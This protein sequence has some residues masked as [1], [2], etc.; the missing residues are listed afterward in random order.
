MSPGNTKQFSQIAIVGVGQVGGAAAY[1]LILGSV[2]SELLLVDVKVDLRDGQVRDL[3]DVAYSVNSGTRVRAATHHEAGQ[4]DIV[5]ITAG[6]RWSIGE[7]NIQHMHRNVSIMRSV[8][9]A[10][11]PFRADAIVLVVSNPVDLLTSIAQEISGLP[12][13]QVLGSGTFLDSVRLRGLL[14]DKTGMAASSIQV[15]VVGVHGDS[16]VVAWSAAT[17][18][19]MPINRSLLPDTLQHA[20]LADECKHRSESIIRA[21]G[22][23]PFGISSVVSSICSSILLD[24]GDVEPIS[25]FQPEFSCCFSLPVILGRKGIMRVI[26]V[27]LDSHE[28][29]DIT[30]SAKRLRDVVERIQ[31]DH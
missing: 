2:A 13:S 10:M 29:A 19:G 3:S 18:N 28:Q 25:H 6:S 12:K 11:R 30:Q 31:N 14:A 4:C 15:S 20:D 21:K 26:A 22:A 17:I 1:A 27:P 9:G 5:V 23:T 8:V 7:T 24:R 16:Q